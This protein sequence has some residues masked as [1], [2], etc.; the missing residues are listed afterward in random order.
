M[1]ELLKRECEPGSFEV[2]SDHIELAWWL[3]TEFADEMKG[4]KYV[5]ERYPNGG[6]IVELTPV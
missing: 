2:F 4:N 3:L 6:M 5:I 1:A